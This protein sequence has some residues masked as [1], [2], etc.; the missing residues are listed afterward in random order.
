M[1]RH[2]QRV[3]RSLRALLRDE[4]EVED[5]MQQTWLA[6]Y[7]HLD[8]FEGSAVF[9]TWLTRIALNEGLARLRRKQTAPQESLTEETVGRLRS[10]EPDPEERAG[11]RE[12]ARMLEAAVD[13][14]P[15]G[16]RVVF[17]LR[18]VDGMATAE[19]AD[20]LG[21]SED[22]VKVRLHRARLALRD[23]LFE[24]VG[25]A[26]GSAFGFMGARCDRMVAAVLALVCPA[27]SA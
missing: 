11:G 26:A 27:A 2:N 5:A 18:A 24:R 23:A 22:V 3:Y 16:Y 13:A 14:L 20:C 9:S 17:V 6:A 7:T 15:E 12:V 1:R 25:S 21:V 10:R 4:R 8:Q 19:V